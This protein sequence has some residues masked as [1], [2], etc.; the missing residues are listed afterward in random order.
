M[1]FRS[2]QLPVS[3]TDPHPADTPRRLR[4]ADRSPVL[5]SSPSRQRHAFVQL[6]PCYCSYADRL[7]DFSSP[8]GFMSSPQLFGLSS[9]LRGFE[10]S[11]EPI[12][13]IPSRSLNDSH[14][15]T[16]T[17][18]RKPREICRSRSRRLGGRGVA[19]SNRARRSAPGRNGV[20]AFRDSQFNRVVLRR[21]SATAR[22]DQGTRRSPRLG[23][24]WAT[25]SPRPAP[26]AA[27]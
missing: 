12:L 27:S 16:K 13:S 22:F 19:F 17:R 26:E 25:L 2:D 8:V 9:V 7:N 20:L 15:G 10:P 23:P 14:E 1:L 4:R 11:C 21:E 24:N 18:S 3:A 6:D 5:P